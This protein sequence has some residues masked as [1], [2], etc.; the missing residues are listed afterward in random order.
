LFQLPS[1]DWIC[2]YDD[3]KHPTG[4]ISGDFKFAMSA[5][6]TEIE[7]SMPFSAFLS[8]SAADKPVLAIGK[9]VVVQLGTCNYIAGNDWVAD[10]T[11]PY[12]YHFGMEE[13]SSGSVGTFFIG[14]FIGVLV[15]AIAI[16]ILLKLGKLS[17]TQQVKIP[18]QPMN[19]N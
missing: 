4:A 5:S 14:L 13:R 11:L 10:A 18:Y 17:V 7:F 6:A 15:V 8:D 3:D 12:V 19:L 1:G 9:S 2:I 16:I